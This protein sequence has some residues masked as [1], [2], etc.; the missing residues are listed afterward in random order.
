MSVRVLLKDFR[1]IV[2]AIGLPHGEDMT[3]Y[4][5]YHITTTDLSA[6]PSR[7]GRICG[8]SIWP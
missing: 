2:I 3:N 7:P 8:G 5:S 4:L 1:K 6:I